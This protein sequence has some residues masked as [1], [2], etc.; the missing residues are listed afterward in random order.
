[1]GLKTNLRSPSSTSARNSK[2]EPVPALAAR[3]SS[4]TDTPSNH[5]PL[6]KSQLATL[7][8]SKQTPAALGSNPSSDKILSLY[9][10]DCEQF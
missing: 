2:P 1:M 7:G 3:F 8:K 5:N 6:A 10:L 9:C 4:A